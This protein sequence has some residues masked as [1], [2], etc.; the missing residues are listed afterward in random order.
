MKKILYNFGNKIDW[1][2]NARGFTMDPPLGVVVSVCESG[3]GRRVCLLV[4]RK[5]ICSGY[6]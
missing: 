3:C 6:T 4:L 2:P 5:Q 1:L